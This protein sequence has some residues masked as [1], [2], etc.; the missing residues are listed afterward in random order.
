MKKFSGFILPVLAA[1]SL[2]VGSIQPTQAASCLDQMKAKMD[3][4]RYL[5]WQFGLP[6]IYIFSSVAVVSA[7]VVFLG[8]TAV[9]ATAVG[10]ALHRDNI[11][12]ILTDAQ[13]GDGPMIRKLWR[14]FNRRHKAEALQMTYE[15]FVQAIHEADANG[16][17]CSEELF[18][19]KNDIMSAVI[20]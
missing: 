17:L 9:A 3:H 15:Q 13:K 12:E 10:I 5:T 16:S 18:V 11:V 6:Y 8:T 4:N 2:F 7:P 20:Q 1:V 14:K 19:E